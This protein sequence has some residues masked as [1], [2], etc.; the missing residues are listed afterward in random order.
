[1]KSSNRNEFGSGQAKFS[2]DSKPLKFKEV[3]K[4]ELDRIKSEIR[5]KARKR[6]RKSV[7]VGIVAITILLSVVAGFTIL[8]K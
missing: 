8:M 2:N 6:N 5:E 4:E 3:D 1:M 7:I